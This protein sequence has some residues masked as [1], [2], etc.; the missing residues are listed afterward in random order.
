MKARTDAEK[1]GGVRTEN[2]SREESW[3]IRSVNNSQPGKRDSPVAERIK[4]QLRRPPIVQPLRSR[5]RE[6]HRHFPLRYA[7]AGCL[8]RPAE[9]SQPQTNST[10]AEPDTTIYRLWNPAW[11]LMIEMGDA[12]LRTT[13]SLHE[14]SS[15]L[16]ANPPVRP[17]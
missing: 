5:S 11:T 9:I 15:S 12:R 7:I 13:N 4:H 14:S 2:V 17:V 10:A 3:T 8:Q 6:F 16:E 1:S